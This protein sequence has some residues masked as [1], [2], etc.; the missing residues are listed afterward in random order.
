MFKLSFLHCIDM[1]QVENYVFK[2]PTTIVVSGSTG[3]GKTTWLK[4]LLHNPELL[5]SPPDKIIYCYGTWQKGFL[6]MHD[7]E[8]RNGVDIPETDSNQHT[9][10]ILDDLMND[11]LKSKKA[12]DLFTKGSHHKNITVI[13]ILQNLFQQGRFARSIML[14]SHYIVLMNNTRDTLQIKHLGRQLGMADAVEEAY[15]DCM[16]TKYN[17][18]IVDLSP[19]NNTKIKLRS[20]I[21]PEEGEHIIYLPK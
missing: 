13:F 9:I 17:Y 8:F 19:H 3:S 4:N 2:C 12:E 20:S 16:M 11:V 10:I 6:E 5:S 14:N 7:V 1:I 21:F 15:K 18:L